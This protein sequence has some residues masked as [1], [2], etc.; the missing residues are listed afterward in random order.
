MTS[1]IAT[2][3]DDLLRSDTRVT[4]AV[5]QLQRWRTRRELKAIF[6]AG[7]E[8][9]RELPFQMNILFRLAGQFRLLGKA[10]AG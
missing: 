2:A 8:V 10:T 6:A 3:H 7:L 5:R 1:S 4:H 9:V